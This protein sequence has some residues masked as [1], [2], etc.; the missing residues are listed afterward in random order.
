MGGDSRPLILTLTL[1]GASFGQL[2]ELR[3]R[4]FPA[5][6][7]QVPAHLTLFHAL[8]GAERVR[9]VRELGVICQ[10]QRRF[11]LQA[12]GPRSL[13]R[14][15][16]ISFASPELVALRQSLA[17][18]WADLLTPQDSARIAPHVTVQNKVAPD[19]ARRLLRELEAE[20]RPFVAQA[21]GVTLWRYLDGPWD[22]DRRFRFGG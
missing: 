18:E 16:A 4:H 14:G 8:P 1:D 12:T 22:L 2:D 15:V 11:P 20:F 19:A 13:G 7:N 5:E 6:R 9:I 17:R 21:E 10:R 3:R